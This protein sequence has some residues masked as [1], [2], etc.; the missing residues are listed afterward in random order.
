MRPFALQVLVALALAAGAARAAD[1]A[2][3][4]PDDIAIAI[5]RAGPPP[6]RGTPRDANFAQ[7]GL[8]FVAETRTLDLPAGRSRVRFEGVAEGII[9]QSAGV[10]G[11]PGP[12][13]ERDFDYD[14]L[15][16]GALVA[17]A[18]GQDVTVVRTNPHTGKETRTRAV[19]RSGPHGVVL[20]FG[21]RV[22]A[23][24]CAG[25]PERLVFDHAPPDLAARP[26]LSVVT[27][28][29]RAGRYQIRLSYLAVQLNWTADYIARVA[30]DGRTLDLTGWITLV[31]GGG[32]GFANAAT[33]V[34]AGN[35]SRVRVVR[36]RPMIATLEPACWPSQTTHSGWIEPPPLLAHS[37]KNVEEIV[38][39]AQRFAAPAMPSAPLPPPPPPPPVVEERL[40]DYHL[41]ALTD[42]TSVAARQTKQ[43]MFLHAPDVRFDV[44]YAANIDQ[45]AGEATTPADRVM[46]IQNTAKTGLGRGLP[47]GAVEVRRRPAAGDGRELLVGEG[48]LQRDTPTGEPVELTIGRDADVSIR[49]SVFTTPPLSYPWPAH[50]IQVVTVHVANAKAV[51]ATV[52]IRHRRRWPKGFAVVAQSE[53]HGLKSG[54]PLWRFVVPPGAAHDLNY[55]VAFSPH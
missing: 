5:Y 26:T 30:P 34:V 9:P 12:L 6:P 42:R 1:V 41:Y 35:L 24:D 15:S 2:S 23:L 48:A 50:L 10:E 38:V 29:P 20:D 54:D 28:T 7:R 32:T 14:L 16:A 49:R 18:I 8:V 21:G 27:D 53:P 46:R 19:I 31:N 3:A 39:T 40:G 52:E 55:T 44:I 45:L 17:H 22:E 47:G 43:V 37:A 33:A 13:V 36:P 4:Q 11:L 25:E 51:P